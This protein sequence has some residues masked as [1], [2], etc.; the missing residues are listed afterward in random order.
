M[1]LPPSSLAVERAILQGVDAVERVT[2]LRVASGWPGEDWLGV[3]PSLIEV[4]EALP[5]WCEW[6]RHIVH[7]GDRTLMGGVG[8]VCPPQED[9][10][11]SLGYWIGA[12]YRRQGFATEAVRAYVA[13]LRRQPSVRTI[14]GECLVAN[15]ASCR[16]LERIGMR[17]AG[18]FED[19]EGHKARWELEGSG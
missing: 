6:N 16:I 17:P 18:F 14:R 10:T 4:Y 12:D 9:G 7:R 15:T 8:C 2:G 11:V 13:W 5:D 1:T 19:A 3:L